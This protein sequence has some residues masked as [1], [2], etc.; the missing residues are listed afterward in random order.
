MLLEQKRGHPLTNFCWSDRSSL[1]GDDLFSALRLS[2][3]SA[4]S[5][6]GYLQ[7]S[8]DSEC[9]QVPETLRSTSYSEPLP[10]TPNATAR[11][12]LSNPLP[13]TSSEGCSESSAFSEGNPETSLD[14]APSD[15][16]SGLTSFGNPLSCSGDR[17]APMAS[18]IKGR[19]IQVI[20][21]VKGKWWLGSM[22]NAGWW[23]WP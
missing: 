19:V 13:N 11:S 17:A 16:K 7:H 5:N 12:F 3:S 8:L 22:G 20:R 14:S 6:L 23:P 1:S 4:N 10:A 18:D 15:P 21:D 9:L 2:R